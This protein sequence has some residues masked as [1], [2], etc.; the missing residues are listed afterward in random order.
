[1]RNTR[2]VRAAYI[3]GGAVVL[4][5]AMA[6]PAGAEVIE[7]DCVGFVEFSNGV[8]IT[9]S[10]PLMDVAEVPAEDTV[11]Y[12]G[13]T[14]LS[15]PAEP[16]D[17]SGSV[18]LALPL[19]GSW[20]IADWPDPPGQTAE[21]SDE[22]TYTYEVPGFVPVGTGAFELTGTHTQRGETCIVAVSV[23]V[24]GSPGPMAILGAAGTFVFGAG[25]IGAGIKRK[26][27]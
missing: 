18:S 12:F 23:A 26:V 10:T 19:G 9:E 3:L 7:G 24:E 4:M 5:L 21:V 14:T 16:E 1:M 8:K 25:V 11:V 13:D 15:P 2:R 20:V 27:V 22:G 6:S 17:F